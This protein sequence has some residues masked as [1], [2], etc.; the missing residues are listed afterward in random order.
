VPGIETDKRR[1]RLG[2]QIDYV[3]HRKGE[4]WRYVLRSKECATSAR[5]SGATAEFSWF[6]R[7]RATSSARA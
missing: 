1:L 2:V 6:A 4:R 7:T 5:S 3:K